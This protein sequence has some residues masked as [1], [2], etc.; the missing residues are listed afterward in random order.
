MTALELLLD[1]T[2]TLCDTVS[3]FHLSPRRDS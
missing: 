3:T 2:Q 1:T